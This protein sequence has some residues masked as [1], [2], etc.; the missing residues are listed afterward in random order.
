MFPLALALSAGT[1]GPDFMRPETPAAPTY[2]AKRDAPPPPDQHVS[3]GETIQGDWWAA[4]RS[5][6]LDSVIRQAIAGNRDVASAKARVAEAQEA[7]T[8]AQGALLPQLSLRA[9][10]G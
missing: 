4:F 9:T 10:V 3:L 6:A 7:V 2:S 1:V 5:P 8:A